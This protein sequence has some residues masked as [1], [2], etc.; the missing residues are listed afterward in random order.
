MQFSE[1]VPEIVP[2]CNNEIIKHAHNKSIL[3]KNMYA[4]HFVLKS[5]W[6]CT[7]SQTLVHT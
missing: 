4:N 3:S 7:F 5:I 2:L 6:P 1:I